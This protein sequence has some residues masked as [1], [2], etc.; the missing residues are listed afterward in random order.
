MDSLREESAVEVGAAEA[1]AE[2]GAMDAPP[3][4]MLLS[5]AV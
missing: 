4:A 5:W 1:A 3:P 2:A